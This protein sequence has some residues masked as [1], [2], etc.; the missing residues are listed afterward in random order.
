M[1]A[2]EVDGLRMTFERHGHGAPIVFVHGYVGDGPSTWRPQLEGLSDEFDVIAW[3]LPGAGGSADPP[4]AFG[5]SGFANALAG[6]IR[7]LELRAPHVVGLSFGGAIVIEFCR[8]HQDVPAAITLVGAY[9]GWAGSLPPEDVDHRLNQALN[10]SHQPPQQLVDALLPTMFARSAA[11]DVVA[12]FGR[13]LASFHPVG[14]RAMARACTENLNDVLPAIRL[15][16]LLIY[17]D[18]DT[19]APSG[20]AAELHDAI[21]H[22]ELVV[23]PGAGHLC[24]VDAA[25][26]F[27][28]TLR[29]FL[30]QRSEGQ[31]T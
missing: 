30:G 6:F 14:L 3:D 27:N 28:S 18:Q 23:L 20:V 12:E 7:A 15:P 21:P 29:S 16:T 22:S 5:M 10:L 17:G 11:P 1:Q 31:R 25:D 24:N 9:A 19:R 4:E 26:A 2:V 8:H 13:A